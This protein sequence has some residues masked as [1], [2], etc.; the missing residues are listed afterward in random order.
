MD[1]GTADPLTRDFNQGTDATFLVD[2]SNGSYTVTATLGDAHSVRNAVALY[3]EGQQV[4]TTQK[5]HAGA[6]VRPSFNVR[7]TDG[8]LNLRFVAQGNGT[9]AAFA[10]NGLSVVTT[11]L[12]ANAGP[13]QVATEG[14]V[15]QFNGSATGTAPFIYQWTFGDGTSASG[16]LQPTKTYADNGTYTVTLSVTDATGQTSQDTALV[17][18]QNAPPTATFANGSG[19]INE[20]GSAVIS[21]NNPSDPSPIDTLGGFHYSFALSLGG[22][23]T[24]YA[25][26][27]DGPA[28]QFSFNDNGSYTVY[29]RIF[30]KDGGYSQYSTTIVV[31]NV[32]PIVTA[33][34]ANLSLTQGVS[35]TVN[36]GS[37]SDPGVNDA[38]W[39]V[40]V[41]WGDSTGST[42]T[43]TTQGALSQAHTYVSVGTYPIAVTVTDKDGGSSTAQT[44]VLVGSASS[45]SSTSAAPSLV[46]QSFDGLLPPV[47]GD[48]DGYPNEFYYPTYGEGGSAT[49]SIDSADAVSGTSLKMQLTSGKIYAQFNPYNYAGNPAYPSLRGFARDYAQGR[50]D[51]QFNTYDR[52][53]FWVKLPTTD[54]SYRTDGGSGIE[55]GTY[56]KNVSNPDPYSDETGG[57]H[58]YHLLNLPALGAWTHVILNMH[59]DH[60]RGGGVVDPGVLAYPTGEAQYNY[61]DA[62][63]RFYLQEPYVAPTAYP[64]DYRIDDIQFYKQPAQENDEQVYSLTGTYQASANRLVL[65]W[66]RDIPE[67]TVRHEVRYAFSDIHAI[68]WDAATPAPNGIIAPPGSGGYNNMRY[69]TTALPLAGH[70][71]VYIAIK[72]QNSNLFTEIAVPL[73]AASMSAAS[74]PAFSNAPPAGPQVGQF[75]ATPNPVTAGSSVTL[76]ASSVQDVNAGGTVTQVAFYQDSNADGALQPGTDTLLGYGTQSGAATWTCTFSTAG[77]PSGWSTLFAQAQDSSGLLSDPILIAL[78]VQ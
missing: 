37:F 43:T 9:N 73:D 27:T 14:Q 21:F 70:S 52:M 44:N 56:V 19:V 41:N 54:T 64:A 63:T 50:A 67:D 69:D 68:G 48:G 4:A 53:S 20:G 15:V 59:P 51:W 60:V 66:N 12:S 28:R 30:D 58:Y 26:A 33:P 1:R 2:L 3:A 46:L 34:L 5:T 75:T 57:G 13:D 36:L 45:V 35:A 16:T 23:A 6:F 25:G 18:V 8:Q 22:L 7:V 49:V 71:I 78:W 11:P 61:F 72:P 76:T 40:A 74:T 42:F 32:A 77:L 31:N 62:L 38:P 39:T 17:T 47:N 10:L 29:G 65:T 55:F 24:S